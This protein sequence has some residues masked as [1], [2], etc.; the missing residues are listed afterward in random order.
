[1][2][3]P[4]SFG[5]RPVLVVRGWREEQLADSNEGV[6]TQDFREDISHVKLTWN[7][8]ELEDLVI[9]LMSQPRHLDTEV[10]VPTGDHVIAYHSYARLVIFEHDSWRSCIE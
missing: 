10:S 8:A 6:I 9:D 7:E 1:M 4:S 3:S 2:T 5:E